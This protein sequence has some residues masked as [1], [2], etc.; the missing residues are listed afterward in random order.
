M[1][2][3]GFLEGGYNLFIQKTIYNSS[4]FFFFFVDIFTLKKEKIEVA[5]QS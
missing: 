2:F 4:V 5:M 3:K 1:H